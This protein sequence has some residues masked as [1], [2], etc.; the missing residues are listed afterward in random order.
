VP[1]DAHAQL[2]PRV[3]GD[4]IY[5]ASG[6]GEVR[7]LKRETGEQ[8]WSRELDDKLSTG[9]GVGAG[10]VLVGTREA[11]VIALDAN[12]GS[13]RW[14]G[15]VSSEMLAR[16]V[17]A[18]KRLIVQ[19]TDGK[20]AA[21]DMADGRQLW[22]HSRSI[23]KLTLRG[24]STPL[25]LGRRVVAGFADGKLVAL[26]IDTGDVQWEA[27]VA[28]SRGRNDLERLVDI[29]GLFAA[30]N[31]VIYVTS[32][33]GRVAALSADDGSTIWA[34]EMSSYTGLALGTRQVF[35]SDADGNIW[36][37]DANTG[38]TL[39]R[40]DR[41]RGREPSAPAVIDGAVV[42]ADYDG[43]V[44]WLSVEDGEFIA[45]QSLGRLW[46]R[47]QVNWG[48]DEPDEE[49]HRSVS[50]PPLVSGQTLYIRDNVGALAALRVGPSAPTGR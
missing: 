21:L 37:L 24:S 11:E 1:E 44:H 3:V 5:L 36:A 49:P 16:P 39:W 46:D 23:P 31:G 43:Y 30:D 8:V 40:Q 17:V 48:S 20:L 12:D 50:A 6:Q 47:F 22:I 34:R 4:R 41:L 7:V 27:T 10:M 15:R 45:R 18:G 35:V 9:P 2:P 14:R 29:D 25:V 33:Q 19:T 28:V 42:V 13:E 32:Y 26:D 38:A